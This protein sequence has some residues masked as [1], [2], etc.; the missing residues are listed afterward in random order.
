M[1]LGVNGK[2][3]RSLVTRSVTLVHV[4]TGWMSFIVWGGKRVPR[5]KVVSVRKRKKR[6]LSDWILN[7][8]SR[9]VSRVT[10]V[11]VKK[12]LSEKAFF[13]GAAG[14][15]STAAFLFIASEGVDDFLPL[16]R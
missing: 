7:G 9:D 12:N 11:M 2:K 5:I 16:N 6:D 15:C 3:E 10:A 1:K 13:F 8:K 4:T 14:V